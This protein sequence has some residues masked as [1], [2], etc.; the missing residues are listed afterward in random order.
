MLRHALSGLKVIDLTQVG[1]GPTCAMLLA[2]MGADVIKL[3]SP[4]GDLARG[5]GPG[6]IGEDA[7]LFHGFNRNKRG[8]VVDLKTT[9][10]HEVVLRLVAEADVLIESMRPGVMDRLGLAQASLRARNPRLICCSISAYGQ[11]GP[12]SRRAGVDGIVQADAG[13][14]SLVGIEGTEPCKVQAPVVDVMTGYV[15]AMAILA[16]LQQR[17]RDGQGAH[18]DVNLFNSALALQQSSLT[19]YLADGRLP[20]RVGSAAPYSAPNQAFATRDGWIMVAAYMPARWTR[21]CEVIGRPDL[22]ADPRFGTSPDRVANREALVSELTATFQTRGN[23]EWLP[24]LQAA[25]IL[26]CPVSNYHDLVEH[27]Q[28]GANRMLASVDHPVHGPVHM[29]GFPVNSRDS[30]ALP[31]RPAPA[32]GQHTLEVL[33]EHGFEDDAIAELVQAKAVAGVDLEDLRAPAS[34]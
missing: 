3:E 15:A 34:P 12:Y 1:A 30:N 26:C 21:L 32:R 22:L 16:Q 6:W 19:S 25:D 10:G 2:D 29:P 8:I 23:A 5:L 28:I 13:L 27:P 17:A 9:R 7:A 31:H 4:E 11:Q 20:E 33:R 24:L 18:L 14:M